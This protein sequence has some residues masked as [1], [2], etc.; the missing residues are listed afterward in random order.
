MNAPRSAD[1]DP[2][3]WF[4]SIH[5]IN[6]DEDTQRWNRAVDRYEVL[7]IETKVR[8]F[9]AIPTPESHHIGCALS[10]R[11]V[12]DLAQREGRSR[13]LGLEDDAVFHT[14]IRVLLPAATA[15]L[16]EL[17]WDLFFLGCVSATPSQT[18]SVL[19]PL[20][21]VTTTHAVAINST[22]FDRILREVPAQLSDM[23][24]FLERYVAI[25]QYFSSKIQFGEF[26]A[27]A[28][29]P[30]LASQPAL[31]NYQNADLAIADRF[32]L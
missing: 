7:G 31:L 10:W 4:E 28:A 17:D 12:V 13:I 21:D 32:D 19:Q 16:D 25:D 11:G 20:S 14:G 24:P 22:A 1:D 5:V 18:D 9:S 8:R 3:D 2:F 29:I 26:R 6:L 15:M 27:Y 30:H 23:T